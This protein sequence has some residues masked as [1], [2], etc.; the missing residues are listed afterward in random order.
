MS[1]PYTINPQD[2]LDAHAKTTQGTWKATGCLDNNCIYS[3]NLEIA[4]FDNVYA[5]I[6]EDEA[7]A[8]FCAIAH[9]AMPEI[10]ERLKRA[11]DLIVEL[12]DAL[13]SDSPE[14]LLQG[15]WTQKQM[16]ELAKE[17]KKARKQ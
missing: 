8:A 9:N 5:T 4:E 12:T 15:V 3:K 14:G 13:H 2:L 16:R 11:E 10:V 1:T 17:I 7:N 6:D